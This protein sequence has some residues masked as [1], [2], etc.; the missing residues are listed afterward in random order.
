MVSR[1]LGGFRGDAKLTTWL[2]RI[3]HQTVRNARRHRRRWSWI[4][5]LTKRVEDSVPADR[6]SPLEN[7]ERNETIAEFYRLLDTLPEK[8]REAIVAV[9]AGGDGRAPDRRA[10]RHQGRDGAR[11]PCT[12][13]GPPF[14][15]PSRPAM[16]R[17]TDSTPA[18]G[19]PEA[20]AAELVQKMGE[21][22]LPSDERMAAIRS[23][24]VLRRGSRRARRSLTWALVTAAL[25]VGATLGAAA[26]GWNRAPAQPF[27]GEARAGCATHVAAPAGRAQSAPLWVG[28]SFA[29]RA[30]GGVACPRGGAVHRTASGDARLPGQGRSVEEP[31]PSGP[32]SA[33]RLESL[34]RRAERRRKP[35]CSAWRSGGSGGIATRAARLRRWTKAPGRFLRGE[36]A[37]EAD[38]YGSKR[39]SRWT[40]APPPCACSTDGSWPQGPGRAR[41]C[42]C[43]ESCAPRPDDAPRRSRIW[44]GPS[45]RRRTTASPN[46]GCCAGLVSDPPPPVSS[47]ATRSGGVPSPLSERPSRGRGHRGAGQLAGREISGEPGRM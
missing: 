14:S 7:S 46:G 15:P 24:I 29:A 17:W 42:S 25:L 37:A 36:L 30:D 40:I 6:P 38:S 8:Y 10:P 16:N 26:R 39:C 43:A 35:G 9:R 21:P 12:G 32:R 4:S 28:R 45:G 47:R 27:A 5:R 2:F 23:R 44:N 1:R 34:Q 11:P 13:R 20:R 33:S 19:T 31:G 41:H 3:T 22:D 18:P